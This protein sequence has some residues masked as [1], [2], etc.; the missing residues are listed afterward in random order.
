METAEVDRKL[1]EL[2]FYIQRNVRYNLRRAAFFQRWSRFTAFVG[3]FLGSASAVTFIS[4]LP[5]YVSVACGMTVA[6]FSALELIVGTGQRFALHCDLRKRYLEL[7]ERLQSE[8]R[9]SEKVIR[10]TW[11]AIRRIEADEPPHMDALEL[12]VRNDVLSS[13][14]DQEDLV[15]HYIPLPWWVRATAQ[16][17]NWDTSQA[18]PIKAQ[19]ATA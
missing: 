5:T 8:S 9:P 18:A 14:Y 19:T 12:M 15:D 6:F 7:D 11:S 13:I 10:E 4:T 1:H 2:N 17:I 3:V 16:W